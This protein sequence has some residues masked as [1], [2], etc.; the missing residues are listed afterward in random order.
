M[1]G[2][3]DRTIAM[4]RHI[5]RDMVRPYAVGCGMAIQIRVRSSLPVVSIAKR[6]QVE[7][8][9]TGSLAEKPYVSGNPQ[10]RPPVRP[11]LIFSQK[12]KYGFAVRNTTHWL[13]RPEKVVKSLTCSQ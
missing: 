10:L 13:A 5:R 12:P 7:R 6:C 9:W 1:P 3:S 8:T 2:S 11:A 4:D